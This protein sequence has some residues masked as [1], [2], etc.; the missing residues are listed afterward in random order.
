M[1]ECYVVYCQYMTDPPRLL[2]VFRKREDAEKY[3]EWNNTASVELLEDVCFWME[4]HI[5]E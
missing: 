3:L 2:R 5:L 4:T 1:D